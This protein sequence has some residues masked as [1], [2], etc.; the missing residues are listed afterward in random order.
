MAISPLIV[1]KIVSYIVKTAPK[2]YNQAGR[3][4]QKFAVKKLGGRYIV[5]IERRDTL[6][7]DGGISQIARILLN[8]ITQE[9]WHIVVRAGRVIHKHRLK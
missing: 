8:N 2:A 1:A 9:V 5:E 3:V 4:I 7:A 6:G